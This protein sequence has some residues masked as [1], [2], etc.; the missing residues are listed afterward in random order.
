[1]R[2]KQ[3]LS[4]D[5]EVCRHLKSIQCNTVNNVDN[6]SDECYEGFDSKSGNDE[7]SIR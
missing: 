7:N 6:D 2:R 5:E 3:K 4:V 1:M